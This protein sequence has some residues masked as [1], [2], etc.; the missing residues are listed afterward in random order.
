MMHSVQAGQQLLH[1]QVV[2]PIGSGGMGEVFKATDSKPSRIVAIKLVPL[3][4]QHSPASRFGR[5]LVETG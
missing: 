2:E 3:A 4:V 1:Y 5:A